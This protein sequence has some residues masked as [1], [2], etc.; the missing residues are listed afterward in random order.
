MLT[1]KVVSP[2]GK[3]LVALASL[4]PPIFPAKDKIPETKTPDGIG[5]NISLPPAISPLSLPLSSTGKSY[6]QI[7]NYAPEESIAPAEYFWLGI[8][9]T[10][11][12][13]KKKG[14]KRWIV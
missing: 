4:F 13:K 3:S 8:F 14:Q 9:H 2:D 7:D 6:S 10:K 12:E 11:K 5:Y 1:R